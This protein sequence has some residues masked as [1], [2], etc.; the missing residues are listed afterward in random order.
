MI[1]VPIRTRRRLGNRS[2]TSPAGDAGTAIEAQWL[3]LSLFPGSLPAVTVT[4]IR[5][6]A[7]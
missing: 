7:R 4:P 3:S 1:A 2:P 5:R 6:T